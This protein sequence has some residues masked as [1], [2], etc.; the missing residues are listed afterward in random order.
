MLS[1]SKQNIVAGQVSGMK[2][3]VPPASFR[4]TLIS[5][6]AASARLLG[7]LLLFALINIPESASAD[8][9]A[10]PSS[11]T[12]VW[13]RSPDADVVG[14]RVYLGSSSRRYTNSIYVG[15]VTANS[16]SGLTSGVS[17]YMAVTALD[18]SGLESDYSAE[19]VYTAGGPRVK[20]S[21]ASNR[22]AVLTVDVPAGQA[23]ELQA[24]TNLT[25]WSVLGSAT[26]ATNGVASFSDTSAPGN[27]LRYYRARQKP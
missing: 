22:Q 8:A 2:M 10:G 25:T 23:Y 1:Y 27:R 24:S 16:F 13:D 14:Y 4:A 26:V 17:Y 18:S 11:M 15:N 3:D 20:V 21:M 9:F 12:L 19:L 6:C 5:Q 7:V